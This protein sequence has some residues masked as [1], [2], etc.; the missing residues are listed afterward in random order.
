VERGGRPPHVDLVILL[1]PDGYGPEVQQFADELQRRT[2]VLQSADLCAVG[3]R[4]DPGIPSDARLVADGAVHRVSELDAIV[5]ALPLITPAGVPFVHEEDRAYVAAELTALLTAVLATARC[6]VLNPPHGGCLSGPGWPPETWAVLARKVGVPT[7][8][9]RRGSEPNPH[10]P[11][12]RTPSAEAAEPDAVVTVCG[13]HVVE[14][15]ADGVLVDRARRLA[16]S[17]G[18]PLLTTTFRQHAGVPLLTGVLPMPDLGRPGLAA[19][20]TRH[21]RECGA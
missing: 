16:E 18:V 11:P 2:V 20:V 12:W 1:I 10:P 4:F 17:A 5:C 7:W 15:D 6:P 19:A 21:L 8:P 14:R 13:R 3:W 9:L